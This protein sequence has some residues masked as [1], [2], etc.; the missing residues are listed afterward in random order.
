MLLVCKPQCWGA[1]RAGRARAD[2]PLPPSSLSACEAGNRSPHYT[3]W[4][5]SHP[6]PRAAADVTSPKAERSTEVPQDAIQSG[7]KIFIT[8]QR[9]SNS[10]YTIHGAP[11]SNCV[12]ELP[13]VTSPTLVPKSHNGVG[14]IIIVHSCQVLPN[15]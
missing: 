11:Q 14:V 9:K 6:R 7:T 15:L 10:L 5:N 3:H 1:C 8:C 13:S 4:F 12:H 2:A